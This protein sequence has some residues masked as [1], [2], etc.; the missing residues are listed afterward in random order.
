MLNDTI[1][2]GKFRKLGISDNLLGHGDIEDGFIVQFYS[3]LFDRMKYDMIED[4]FIKA[5]IN[6]DLWFDM[7]KK[8]KVPSDLM[9][10]V[11]FYKSTGIPSSLENL[12][13]EIGPDNRKGFSEMMFMAICG[14]KSEVRG[15]MWETLIN[16]HK[17][18]KLK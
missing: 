1:L 17:E 7:A 9:K 4:N 5:R 14:I 8:L 18:Y 12:S 2:D 16:N 15:V 3:M 10:S 6:F 11:K 13:K